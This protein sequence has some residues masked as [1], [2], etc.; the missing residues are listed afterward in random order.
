MG[1]VNT[2]LYTG[3]RWL[4]AG[5]GSTIKYSIDNGATWTVATGTIPTTVQA[6]AKNANII[7]ATGNGSIS[8]STDNGSTWTAASVSFTGQVN[9]VI[10]NTAYF[11]AGGADTSPIKYSRDGRTWL[12]A[13]GIITSE[14]VNSIFWTG[15]KTYAATTAAVYESTDYGRTWTALATQPTI[16][17]NAA[18]SYS[19]EDRDDLVTNNTTFYSADIPH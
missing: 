16:G 9:A 3:S 7:I 4:S 19:V 17:S 1:T 14:T 5:T 15:I 11:V 18:I 8:Y 12:N 10:W 2:L 6:L 13:S